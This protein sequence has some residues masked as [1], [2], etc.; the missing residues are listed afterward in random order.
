MKRFC[1][2]AAFLMAMS[3]GVAAAEEV[4]GRTAAAPRVV[5]VRSSDLDLTRSEDAAVMLG[6]L[7]TAATRACR[8]DEV[9][10]QGPA[11]RRAISTCREAAMAEAVAGIDAP[12][13]SRL[14]EPQRR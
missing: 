7:R 9:R 13:L 3:A 14:Y 8:V 1:F 4:V 11:L 12:E 6:R 5:P 2:A 10:Q